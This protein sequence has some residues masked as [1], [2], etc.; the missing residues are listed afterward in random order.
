[1]YMLCWEKNSS[2]KFLITQLN[3]DTEMSHASHPTRAVHHMQG[4]LHMHCH[5]CSSRSRRR[6]VAQWLAADRQL[7]SR[8]SSPPVSH[9]AGAHI[10]I[11]TV[12]CMFFLAW[13]TELWE[14]N[15]KLVISNI[16]RATCIYFIWSSGN[17]FVKNHHMRNEKKNNF[18]FSLLHGPFL[19]W[20]FL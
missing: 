14:I 1:M 3:A 19:I 6:G 10:S 18:D 5:S 4:R 8:G 16:C 9:L 7:T 15:S 17:N 11:C 12:V 2:F 13:I 20:T